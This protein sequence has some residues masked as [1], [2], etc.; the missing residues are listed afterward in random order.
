M[1]IC[2]TMITTKVR[3]GEFEMKLKELMTEYIH[4]LNVKIKTTDLPPF[5]YTNELAREYGLDD[6]EVRGISAT[7]V[8][9]EP[10]HIDDSMCIYPML[11]IYVK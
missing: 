4:T 5:I 9:S 3:K 7:C 8:S 11:V 6:M 1:F 2:A 10:S